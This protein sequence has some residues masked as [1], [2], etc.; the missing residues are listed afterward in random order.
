MKS[1]EYKNPLIGTVW[2]SIFFWTIIGPMS[3]P[4]EIESLYASRYLM[5][6]AASAADS[7]LFQQKCIMHRRRRRLPS[8]SIIKYEFLWLRNFTGTSAT[9]G[10]K[11]AVVGTASARWL[12]I[13]VPPCTVIPES[14]YPFSGGTPATIKLLLLA[15]TLL[16]RR[17]PTDQI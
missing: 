4:N 9:C 8:S 16:S 13:K 3:E 10:W 5:T 6:N 17:W 1:L 2:C 12:V 11:G 7:R 15:R 14:G